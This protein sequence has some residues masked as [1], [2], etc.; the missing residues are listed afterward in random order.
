VISELRTQKTVG[1]LFGL[2][3]M[4]AGFLLLPAIASWW[5]L[6]KEIHRKPTIFEP[7]QT[8]RFLHNAIT[9]TLTCAVF[10]AVSFMTR[11]ILIRA[12][13]TGMSVGYWRVLFAGCNIAGLAFGAF[14]LCF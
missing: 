9:K 6:C 1:M 11:R 7:L 10:Q 8:D 3:P 2:F 14:T 4:L 12:A 13:D 5:Q